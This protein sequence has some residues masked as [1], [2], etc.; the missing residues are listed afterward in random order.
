M[1]R[2]CPFDSSRTLVV[3]CS[4]DEAITATTREDGSPISHTRRLAL[5]KQSKK[6]NQQLNKQKQ[7]RQ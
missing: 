2:D 1:F 4:V 6:L 5:V 7:K 3:V